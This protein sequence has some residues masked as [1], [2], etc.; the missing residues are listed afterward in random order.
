M[1]Q[2]KSTI[3]ALQE[4]FGKD[5]IEYGGKELYNDYKRNKFGIIALDIAIGGGIPQRKIITI[6]GKYSSGKTTSAINMVAECQRHGGKVAMIDTEGSFDPIWAK[7]FGVDYNKVLVA[8]PDT[9]EQVSDVMESLLMSEE[10]DLI[11]FDSVA[12]TPAAAELEAS[13]E[14]K[15]MGGIAKAVGLMMRKI[16]ARL[17]QNKSIKTSILIINQLRDKIGGW[18]SAEYMPGGNQLHNQSD[19]IVYLRSSGWIG[20]VKEPKGITIKFRVSKNK[21]APPLK[22][23][24]YDLYFKGYVNNKKTLIKKAV[25]LGIIKKGGA[26]YKIGKKKV[27]GI[28]GVQK[29][30]TEEKVKVL[31]EKIFEILKEENVKSA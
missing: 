21:T 9:I 14:Q 5:F 27:Q 23:G 12:A 10:L 1:S 31:R 4:K 30:L 25:A 18:G 24:V 29:L 6:A 11:V 16:R 7:K 28:K 13:A 20:D 2:L 15:S 3:K 22:T 8:Q 19:I 26:W 17:N